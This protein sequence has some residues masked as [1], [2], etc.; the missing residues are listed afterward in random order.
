MVGALRFPSFLR[1]R[2]LAARLRAS[3]FYLCL[4][5]LLLQ[6]AALSSGA[7]LHRSS[8]RSPVFLPSSLSHAWAAIP[9]FSEQ[10]FERVSPPS[11]QLPLN[12][13]H[14]AGLGFLSLPSFALAPLPSRLA[15]S[16]RFSD[17]RRLSTSSLCAQ[18]GPVCK[19]SEAE[20]AAAVRERVTASKLQR[21]AS[22]RIGGSAKREARRARGAASSS[23]SQNGNFGAAGQ[24]GDGR[25][26]LETRHPGGSLRV[27]RH[28]FEERGDKGPRREGG[29]GGEG[30]PWA[31]DS[32][33]RN[34]R[35][36][37]EAWRM[38]RQNEEEELLRMCAENRLAL[39]RRRERQDTMQEDADE[40]ANRQLAREKLEQRVALMEKQ[41]VA[42][43]REELRGQEAS[44]QDY[45][46]TLQQAAQQ[47][48]ECVR[49]FFG[50]ARRPETHREGPLLSSSSSSASSSPHLSS[51]P[52]LPGTTS[53][54][55]SSSA[56]SSP[57]SSSFPLSSAGLGAAVDSRSSGESDEPAPPTLRPFFPVR[58]FGGVAVFPLPEERRSLE[59]DDAVG[60]KGQKPSAPWRLRLQAERE[61]RT[62][63]TLRPPSYAAIAEQKEAEKRV[64]RARRVWKRLRKEMAAAA[65]KTSSERVGDKPHSLAEETLEQ[66]QEELEGG[67]AATQEE[68]GE[69]GREEEQ[70]D[71]QAEEER[72]ALPAAS[73][74]ASLPSGEFKPKQSLG[75]NFLSDPNISRLIATSLEDA[76]PGGVG[77]VEVGPGSGAITRFLLPKFPRMS[78]VET[79]PRA[80]SLLSRRLP[81]LNIIHGDVLQVSWPDLARER[82]TRLSVAGNLPFYLTSQLLCCLLDS[83][84]FIDQAL[85]TIQ[86]EM[87]ERL[88][89]RVGERQYS[90]LSVVF[91]LYGACRIVKKL[92]RSVF[93]PVPKVDAA[94]VH[95]KF[96]QEPLEKILCGVDPRQFRN[97]LHAAFGQR[98]KMLRSSLKPVLPHSG[99]VPERFASLR[100]QQLSPTDFLELTEAIFPSKDADLRSDLQGCSGREG[101]ETREERPG[102]FLEDGEELSRIWRKEKHGDY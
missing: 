65:T 85:V 26:P 27:R 62:P 47:E 20:I 95:I 41:L 17:S 35:A 78:A 72:P 52:S 34:S 98:R 3:L 53:C 68:R 29:R 43:K 18:A 2:S 31:R 12:S 84:R 40:E 71:E 36:E 16:L 93:Y 87:A 8:S 9:S 48:N 42:W 94:L 10:P 25:L 82:G 21:K 39:E 13:F 15:L 4:H 88:T 64:L 99:A 81:T 55:S 60:E 79:D 22:P 92:P 80:V 66:R 63:P 24:T 44:F 23:P 56:S 97:V 101:K 61:R 33:S 11:G 37:R 45:L 6:H 76:S 32:L 14:S 67:V 90:R 102:R 50:D 100:P 74:T 28:P 46:S 59:T 73:P 89:A 30:D 96:R 70:R 75:Q 5:F 38:E 91:A 83:W 49:R 1:S 51:P 7:S 86:W 57:H 54:L 58:G 77:V 69:R 19:P